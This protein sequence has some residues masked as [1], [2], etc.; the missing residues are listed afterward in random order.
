MDEG[1]YPSNSEYS[2]EPL[3]DEDIP[4][5]IE[6]DKQAS[7]YK[8]EPEY[9]EKLN[10][11][12]GSNIRVARGPDRGIVGA[13]YVLAYGIDTSGDDEKDPHGDI[14]SLAVAEGERKKGVGAMLMRWAID[15]LKERN[16]P[17]IELK[18]GVTNVAMQNLALK[19]GFEIK[20]RL[21]NFYTNRDGEDA[22]RMEL[23]SYQPKAST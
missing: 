13:V 5:F 17:R 3:K 6:L 9:Y 2:L 18:T 14:V 15:R 16:V 7:P 4:L 1:E 21:P 11:W 23:T 20:E 8:V 22:Y 10:R 12:F 19:M